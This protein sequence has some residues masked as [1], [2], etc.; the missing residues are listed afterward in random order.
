M[1]RSEVTFPY[2]ESGAMQATD[3]M[4][5]GN[6]IQK[7]AAKRAIERMAQDFQ[8][9]VKEYMAT[10]AI[11]ALAIAPEAEAAAQVQQVCHQ[12]PICMTYSLSEANGGPGKNC[13]GKHG[14]KS[15]V[16]CQIISYDQAI[17]CAELVESNK[18][19]RE[20]MDAKAAAKDTKAKP[21]SKGAAKRGP[22]KPHGRTTYCP[23][24]AGK[25]SEGATY[26]AACGAE[27]R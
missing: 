4:M 25:V 24:V 23:N 20:A 12:A 8:D 26:C 6:L 1:Q 5:N 17:L 16:S 19:H 10:A 7:A 9:A 22:Q 13:C 2:D 11:S 15:H 18:A 14:E 27:L 3:M 21:N